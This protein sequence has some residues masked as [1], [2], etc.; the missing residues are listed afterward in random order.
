VCKCMQKCPFNQ[1]EALAVQEACNSASA[2][3]YGQDM[4][5]AAMFPDLADHGG[6]PAAQGTFSMTEYDD[7]QQAKNWL[8]KVQ[9]GGEITPYDLPQPV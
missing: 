9:G 1:F 8:N 2:L 5:E 7:Q 3:E 6:N 4:L